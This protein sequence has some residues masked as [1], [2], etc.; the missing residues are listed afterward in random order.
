MLLDSGGPL[1]GAHTDFDIGEQVVSPYLWS[2]GIRRLDVVAYS[3]PHSDHM[4]ALPTIIRNFRPRELWIGFAP[5]V[6]DVENVLQAAREEDTTVTF[7][8]TGDERDFGGAH[9]RFLLPQ[10]DQQPHIPPKDDDVLAFKISYG[11]TSALFI[12][13]A[14]KKQEREMID[15]SPSADLLKIAHHGST[16]SSSPEF[17]AAVHPKFG[18]IS[19]GARNSFKHPRPEVLQRLAAFHVRTYRTDLAGATT[20]YLNGHAV[21][22]SVPR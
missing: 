8:R 1:G 16:T 6:R 10:K 21:T 13:D 12:G 2:R 15:L 17:L 19:V 9:I 4:G 18:V 3:H 5:P 14:H 7:Y 22:A 11:N 20:F